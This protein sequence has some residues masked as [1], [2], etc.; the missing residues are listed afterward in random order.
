[1]VDMFLTGWVSFPAIDHAV[2]LSLASGST[3]KL[4]NSSYVECEFRLE[5]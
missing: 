5:L 4:R 1:M 2:E 3:N